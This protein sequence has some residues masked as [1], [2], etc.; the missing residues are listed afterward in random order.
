[1]DDFATL[2]AAWFWQEIRDCPGRFVLARGRTVIAPSDLVGEPASLREFRVPACR[3]PVLVARLSDGGLI[4][5]R[6]EDGGFTHTL[7]TAEGLA[8]KLAQ[9]G[10]ALDP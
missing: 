4:S 7:N 9:L 2:K 3:D 10:I 6:H 8:R 1:M 5:Y